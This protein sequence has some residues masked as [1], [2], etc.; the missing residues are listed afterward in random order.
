MMQH[1]LQWESSRIMV[2]DYN[3]FD[4][5]QKTLSWKRRLIYPRKLNYFSTN[6]VDHS[7]Q[8]REQMAKEHVKNILKKQQAYKDAIAFK[9]DFIF[10]VLNS[11]ATKRDAKSYIQRFA[12][13][14]SKHNLTCATKRR[15][16][17]LSY[18]NLGMIYEPAAILDSPKFIQKPAQSFEVVK[19]IQRHLAVVK[20]RAIQNLSDKTVNGIGRTIHQLSRLGLNSIIVLDFNSENRRETNFTKRDTIR[21]K[22]EVEQSNRIINAINQSGENIARLVDNIVGVSE[23]F[24]HAAKTFIALPELLATQLRRGIIAVILPIGY[25]N[26]TIKSLAV[27]ANEIVLALTRELGGF[28]SYLPQEN[29]SRDSLNNHRHILSDDNLLDRLIMLDPLGGIPTP[30]LCHGYH[31][32]LNMIEEYDEVRQVL[33]QNLPH[34]PGLE[35]PVVSSNVLRI[36][37]ELL[38]SQN[39]E[40]RSKVSHTHSNSNE[41]KNGLKP[42]TENFHHLEN[43]KLTRDV[44][45]ILPPSSSALLISP[46]EVARSVNDTSHRPGFVGTRRQKNPLIHNLL[47]DKSIF[48]PSLPSG[49]RRKKSITSESDHVFDEF[50]MPITFAK[51]GIPVTIFPDP[52]IAPWTPK[53]GPSNLSLTNSDINLPLLVNLINDSFG[54][55]LDVPAYLARVENRI[56]GVIIA[57]EYEGG[58]ILTW[59]TPPGME[60]TDT[61]CMVPYLDKFAVLRRSQG[62]GGVADLIFNCIVR[63]CFPNGVVWRSRK[64]NPVNKW[65]FERSRG[66]WKLS[67]SGWIM[68]WTTPNMTLHQNEQ[69]LLNYEG[70]CRSIQSTWKEEN[71]KCY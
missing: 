33:L 64:N 65:Y 50:V 19:E 58:A 62:S 5:I 69:L 24:N 22:L 20:I 11:S 40:T 8:L 39:T 30:D 9:T 44:L 4:K 71:Q 52:K 66:T 63:K 54:R 57:G 48:S 51:H 53:T 70:V 2:Y 18:A 28:S 3:R 49:R 14:D 45:S 60:S 68:F 42:V 25:T 6:F 38:S 21:L 7:K 29:N 46:E 55:T 56:A 10:S 35:P 59:E 41:K 34:E 27:P 16:K 36:E 61:S 23:N 67:Q 47:T 37:D 15:P 32:Y 13:S 26:L 12:L 43:L 31:V 1:S 17:G